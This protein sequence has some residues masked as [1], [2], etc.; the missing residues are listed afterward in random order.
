MDIKIKSDNQNIAATLIKPEGAKEPLPALIFVHGWKSDKRG[1]VKRAVEIS[2]LGFICLC[3]DLRGHGNS[4]G[5]IEDFSRKDHLEDIKSA[6]KYLSELPEVKKNNIGI[7]GSSYGG[8]LAAV[9]VNDLK[10]N[11]LVL[12]VPALYFDDNFDVPTDKLIN[13]DPKAFKTWDLTSENSLALKGV[14]NFK[15]KILIIEA[16]KDIVIP[17][18]VINNYRNIADK[19]NTKFVLMRDTPHSLETQ[20]Q[21]DAYLYILKHWL[22][23][24][25]R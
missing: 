18:E 9:A 4:D 25:E 10:F 22:K 20:Q 17:T 12:R 2:K 3:I 24:E 14:K 1:N 16:E 13:G 6:Y 5:S 11:R 8:Y 23:G 21:E 7:I 19:K 15:G